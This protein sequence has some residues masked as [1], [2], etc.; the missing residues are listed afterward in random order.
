MVKT[1]GLTHLALSVG[2]IDRSIEFYR[3]VLGTVVVYRGEKFAQVQ[4]PGARDAIVFEEQQSG[5]GAAGGVKHFGFR[6]TDPADI[7]AALSAVDLAGGKI[8]STGE[9]CP[10]EPFVFFRD[11]DGY[12]VEIWY[13]LPTPVDPPAL[14]Q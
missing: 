11:P 4:T 9:F 8:L 5:A 14:D 7:G 10:G 3:E 1:Y 13:E 2:D 6:L 12:E